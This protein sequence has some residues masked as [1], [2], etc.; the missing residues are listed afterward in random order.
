M[1]GRWKLNLQE[2]SL[3]RP[4][5]SL[6]FYSDH[7]FN[8][9]IRKSKVLKKDDFCF[10]QILYSSCFSQNLRVG[11]MGSTPKMLIFLVSSLV[12]TELWSLYS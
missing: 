6:C 1:Y 12:L 11:G 9:E 10:Q 3:D 8:T 7:K 4:F 5:Q 2:C